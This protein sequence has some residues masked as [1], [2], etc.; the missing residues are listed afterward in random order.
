MRRHAAGDRV[1]EHVGTVLRCDAPAGNALDL[2]CIVQSHASNPADPLANQTLG[3]SRGQL[4][5]KFA[6]ALADFL[7]VFVEMNEGSYGL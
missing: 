6:L 4:A 1:A 3:C 7:Q 2:Q 5:A